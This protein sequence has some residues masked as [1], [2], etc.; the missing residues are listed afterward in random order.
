MKTKVMNLIQTVILYAIALEK[1][2]SFPYIDLKYEAVNNYSR[3]LHGN[4][5]TVVTAKEL[6]NLEFATE[7]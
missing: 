4:F 2:R 5:A 3:Q 6:Y 7:V 1:V